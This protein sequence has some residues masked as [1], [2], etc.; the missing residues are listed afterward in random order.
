MYVQYTYIYLHVHVLYC[1]G[2]IRCPTCKVIHG[3]RRGDMPSTG[4]SMKVSNRRYSLPGHEGYG[5]IEIVY[6]FKPGVQVKYQ[7][8]FLSLSLPF[9]TGLR[10]KFWAPVNVG[11]GTKSL[12]PISPL[13]LLISLSLSL[14]L[15]WSPLQS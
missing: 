11:I 13:L 8:L 10:Q 14:S 7:P 15:E 3:V 1:Q 12:P 5:T 4:C 2:C 9:F 6:D